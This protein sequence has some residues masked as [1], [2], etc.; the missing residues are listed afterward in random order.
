MR[1]IS[2]GFPEFQGAA[3]DYQGPEDGED[4]AQNH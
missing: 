4:G 1:V 2:A 3:V